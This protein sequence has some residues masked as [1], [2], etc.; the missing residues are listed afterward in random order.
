[1]GRVLVVGGHA[2]GHIGLPDTNI[3]NPSTDTWTLVRPMSYPR[4]YPTATALP[5]GRVLVTSG[6]VNCD[7]CYV[8]IPE[9]YN[10]Q[11]IPGRSCPARL[12][13]L[14]YY[15]HMF[16]LPDGRVLAASTA[17]DSI[18]TQVLDLATQ[19]WSVVD[20][21]RLMAAAR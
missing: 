15:P 8:E 12:S 14:P 10:P 11:P 7:G 2:G 5:D 18:V 21:I 13:S 6:E 3:F 19:T 20:P 9:V 16:V 4:W 1:M 17:E